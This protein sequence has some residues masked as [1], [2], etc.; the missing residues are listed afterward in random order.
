ML[1]F[2]PAL[3]DSFMLCQGDTTVVLQEK[4]LFTTGAHMSQATP[5]VPLKP[6]PLR[7]ISFETPHFTALDLHTAEANIKAL[8]DETDQRLEALLLPE[9]T[10]PVDH[11]AVSTWLTAFEGANQALG[12]AA[13][14]LSHLN[15]VTNTED[16]TNV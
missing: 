4:K 3:I 14:V 13:T 6:V 7:E 1:P 8:I 11:K 10:K 9:A 5:A 2:D 15:H 12:K 16:L